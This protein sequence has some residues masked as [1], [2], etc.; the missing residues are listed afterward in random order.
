MN[1]TICPCWFDSGTSDPEP[2][3]TDEEQDKDPAMEE[4]Q[5][6][7]GMKLS[8]RDWQKIMARAGN[9]S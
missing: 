7:G 8:K 4:I 3:Y 6:I 1:L 2:D 9:I 5:Q